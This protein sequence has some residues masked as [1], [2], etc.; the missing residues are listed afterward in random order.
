[1]NMKISRTMKNIIYKFLLPFLFFTIVLASCEKYLSVEPKGVRLLQT[2]TDYDQWL[3]STELETCFPNEI[4]ILADNVDKPDILDPFAFLR[5]LLLTERQ[6]Y[7]CRVRRND[8][9]AITITEYD[10]AGM[11]DHTPA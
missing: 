11:N 8:H 10:I 1:M 3:N 5:L 4:N 7:T 6:D 9:D 2:V